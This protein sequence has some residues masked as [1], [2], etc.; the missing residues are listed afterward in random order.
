MQLKILPRT[1]QT[2]AAQRE[3]LGTKKENADRMRWGNRRK[4]VEGGNK[5]KGARPVGV[6]G[7]KGGRDPGK[8]ATERKSHQVAKG[9]KKSADF[10][11]SWG[12]KRSTKQGK[13]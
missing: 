3:N 8:Y 9:C 11:W 6:L 5:R 1:L 10:G 4:K 13:G 2:A 7:T 12:K